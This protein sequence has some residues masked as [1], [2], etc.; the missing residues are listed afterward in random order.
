MLLKTRACATAVAL[1]LGLSTAMA[2]TPSTKPAPGPAPAAAPKAPVSG[3]ILAQD[4]NSMLGKEFIGQAVYTPD[5]TKIGNI[6]D[7]IL[8]KDGKSV[9]GIVI[10]VGGFLGLGERNVALKTEQ[11]KIARDPNDALT[12]TLDVKKDELANAPEF[13][14]RKDQASEKQAS[15]PQ[16]SS[17]SGGGG[18]APRP[19][20]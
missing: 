7:I 13:K 12:L 4:A 1:V 3:Q 5:K 18:S 16:T 20:N 9:E 2:Q 15:R 10:G 6:S 11:L 17:P 19:G 8:S 14:S